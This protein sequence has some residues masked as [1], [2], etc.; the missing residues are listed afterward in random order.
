MSATTDPAEREADAMARAVVRMDAP[1]AVRS[2][3]TAT[4]RAMRATAAGK[5]AETSPFVAA[6]EASAEADIRGNL[7]GGEPLPARVRR[8]M[9]PR[10]RADF[11]SVR[12]HTDAA[13]ASLAARLSARAFA[14]DNHIFFGRGEFRPDSS[15]GS[16]LIAHELTH[17]IQQRAVVQR[18]ELPAV[19]QSAPVRVQRLG[20]DTVLDYV[21]DKANV[22]PGFR[23]FTIVLGV[24]P[25]NMKSVDASPGNVLRA[26][27]EFMPGAGF[28]TQALD[29]SGVFDKVANWAVQ[30]VKTLGF[31]AASIAK[32]LM[33]YLKSLS[34]SDFLHPGAAWERA[35]TMFTGPIGR[36][37]SFVVDLVDG[38]VQFVKD[39]ILKPV[40]KLAEGT[41]SY[42][43]LKGVLGKD[44]ITDEPAPDSADLLIGGFMKLIGQNDVWENMKKAGAVPKAWAWFKSSMGELKEFVKQIPPTFISAFK[45]LTLEDIILV[46]RA[47]AK[48]VGVFATFVAKFMS[49][50]GDAVWK[51][52]EIV[53]SVVAPGALG[54]I[55]RTGAALNSILK[56]PIPFVG[57]LV[58]AAKLGFQNFAGNFGTHLKN[59]LIDWLTGSLSGVYIPQA[60]S[61]G[62]IVKFAFSVLGLTWQ[63]LRG[64]LVKAVGETAVQAMEKGFEIVKTLVTKGPAA[65]W[66]Q[67]KD[68]LAALKDK[69]IGG[70]KDMVI[71]AVVTKAIPKLIA[72]FIP[73][74]GFISAIISIYETVMVFVQKISKIIQ[75][76]TAFI[77]SIVA[78]AAGNIGAAAGR[79]ESILAGLLSL[80]INFLAGFAGLGKIA[81]KI[82][83]I[84]EKIRAPIDKALDAM[85]AWI[86]KL[87][88]KFFTMLKKGAKK[89]LNWWKKN[90]PFTGGGESHTVI[91]QGDEENAQLMVRSTPKRPED[92]VLDFVPTGQSQAET[93]QVAALSK[94][95]DGLKKKIATAANK[96]PPDEATIAAID[97]QLTAKFNALGQL[98]AT[99][100]DKAD[101]EGSEKNPVAASYP[102]RRAAAYPNIYV[103]PLTEEY[104]KQ[105]W[106][107]AAADAG[108]GKK[109]KD[110]LEALDP[111][112]A[113][114]AGFRAWS[115]SVIAAR[116]SGGPGQSLPN[117]TTV[118]LDAA[119]ASL[120]PGKVLMYDEKGKTGGGSKINNLF[121]PFGFRAGK[122]GLDGDHVME[123]Q[124]G[125]PDAI[126]NLWPLQSGENRS[127][128]STLNSMKVTFQSQVM[129]VHEA[130]EK[131]Q[132]KKKALFILIKSTI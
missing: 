46:P 12:I 31:A 94:D 102:K 126:N 24:N 116:A 123:R 52:L 8:F 14:F 64:K 28:V 35:K 32:A 11:S 128:G 47:F 18:H 45:S 113:N 71:E 90:A 58:Q 56:N 79:V 112:L 68:E 105:D 49:W 85:V 80:A 98:L 99:L 101:D 75:V 84:I 51:L 122:E 76:V 40:A 127:S 114:D 23:M 1:R 20:L 38:I 86:R 55:K 7:N 110:K 69:V 103:G 22:L 30:Q 111:A 88:T 72:M 13:A 34:G 87:G 4:T 2:T 109:A 39:A 70:I 120:A 37:K 82:N 96:E 9:E 42:D 62:E 33:D 59:G 67:I 118:G 132:K 125:G 10:F 3:T 121:K 100:L 83:G 21:A 124:L 77:D 115:G 89:L 50:A 63:N 66:E 25:I 78:I 106:L 53:F 41:P 27:I 95:I 97:A 93:K 44:P 26:L 73:G 48:L 5:P 74:A 61:L 19:T 15:D 16:E 36:I 131:R 81:A 43:L 6:A 57:N 119:F 108:S 54:Y 29:N 60:L 65:A 129:S 107:K 104:V 91:F 117:G 17:T 92:F 130:R